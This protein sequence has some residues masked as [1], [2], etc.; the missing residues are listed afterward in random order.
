M[1][2]LGAVLPLTFWEW[3]QSAF[4]GDTG[5]SGAPGP[6]GPE[7]PA[8][9]DG[10]PGLSGAYVKKVEINRTVSTSAVDSYA[11]EVIVGDN[12]GDYM[13]TAFVEDLR[14]GPDLGAFLVSS[15]P[16]YAEGVPSG[17]ANGMDYA[18]QK[19]GDGS[20]DVTD[21]EFNVTIYAVFLPTNVL[22]VV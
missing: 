6:V 14:I 5:A 20:V 4:H 19:N 8:G 22:D 21:Q 10:S 15:S 7:G 17:F 16:R 1:S 13:V 12:P 3:V 2:V 11:P 18:Y 9:E